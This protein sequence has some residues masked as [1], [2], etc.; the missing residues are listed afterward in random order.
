MTKKSAQLD[1]VWLQVMSL[2]AIDKMMLV[3]RVA[4]W[5][6]REVTSAASTTPA[7]SAQLTTGWGA[8]IVQAIKSGEIDTSAWVEMEIEDPVQWV[9]A[10]RQN[11]QETRASRL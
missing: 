5:F 8:Q 6:E 4:S 11:E 10:R 2:S 7:I 3:E 1:E 9:K